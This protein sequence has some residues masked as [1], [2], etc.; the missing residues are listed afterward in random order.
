MSRIGTW[1]RA[2][3]IPMWISLVALAAVIALA[4][5]G[6]SPAWAYEENLT[7][8]CTDI[9][10]TE[11]DTFRLH[12]VRE[13]A[14]DELLE[15]SYQTMKVYWTTVS[16]TADESDYIPL[17]HE[18]QASNR[19]QSKNDRMG[20][21]FYTTEDDL[22]EL[23]EEFKV[24]V[25]NANEDGDG[26]ECT[27]EIADDDGPGSVATLISWRPD[28]DAYRRGDFIQ[29]EL[30]YN[31]HVVV[32]GGTPALGLH[33]GEGQG[34]EPNRYAT[35]YRGSEFD[36]LIFRYRVQPGDF[37]PD[38]ITVVAGELA[39]TGAV[40]T[41][42]TDQAINPKHRGVAGDAGQKVDAATRVTGV[43][44]TSAPEGGETYRLG[45]FIEATA[46]FNRSV[47]VDGDVA[48][49]L[50][51]GDG[52][53]SLVEAPYHAGSGT[54]RLVFR[55]QV[56]ADD[57]DTTG[58]RVVEGT[59][60][61]LENRTGLVGSGKIV[62]MLDG[63]EIDVRTAFDGLS[64][65]SGHKVDGRAY[66]KSVAV[67]SSPSDGDHY[68]ADERIMVALSFDR[69]VAVQPKPAIK[70]MVGDQEELARFY[71]GSLTD[72]VTFSYKVDEDD[73]DQD[74]ISVPRQEGFLA[75]GNVW[76]AD[77]RR[78]LDERIPV[79]RNQADHRVN[80]ILPTVVA[81]EIASDPA[82]GGVYRYGETIEIALE[83]DGEV[84]VLGR[85]SIQILLDGTDSPERN[86]VYSRGSGTDTLTFAY[87][88]QLAD[89]DH[90]GVGLAERDTGGFGPAT[91]RVYQAGTENT[92]M[93]HI[94][95]FGSA[96]G[97]RVDGRPYVTAT[98]V[99]STPASSG[100]Y[101]AGETISVALTYDRPM[102]VEG[103]PSIAFEIG[104]HRSEATYRGGS[105]T[106]TI[107]FGYDVQTHDRDDDGFSLP[108]G[109]GHA[110][111]DGSIF[112]AGRE[113]EVEGTYPGFGDLEAHKVA[114]QVSVSSISIGSDPGSDDTY[115]PGDTIRVLVHFDDEVIVTGAPRL[116]LDLGGSTVTANFQGI[117]DQA[118]DASD[119]TG[120]VLIF[121]YT[122]QDGDG[123]DDGISVVANSLNLHGGAIL[124][125]VGNDPDL[126]HDAA[127]FAGH[128]VGVVPP[129]LLSA[130]T[131]AD[132]QEVVLTFSENIDVRPDLRTLSRF[133]GIHVSIYPRIL[134]DIFVDGHRAHTH[135]PVISGAEL[136]FKMD[137]FIRSGQ[138]VTVGYDDVFARDLP[139]ILVDDHGNALTRFDERAVSNHSTLSADAQELWP[140]LSAYS[141]TVAEGGTGSYT[142]ALGSQPDENVT[143]TLVISPSGH[144]TAS[145]EEL[146]FTPENWSSP[147][148]V[149]LTAGTDD[150]DINFWQEIIHSST[151]E[152]FVVGHVKVLVED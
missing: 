81:S 73:L 46:Q 15:E 34:E 75:S 129:M 5:R 122:V 110:F 41:R 69:A 17:H 93:G 90:D 60:A 37:D 51:V 126:R 109:D 103:V 123:D 120:K 66:V 16:G 149:A 130:R 80:G 72:T 105:G 30:H 104:D 131:T 102:V 6:M 50:E 114:G 19:F 76:E 98:S 4:S 111:H 65:Q 91:T 40:K 124:D 52:N 24:E 88:V 62:E 56:D 14:T 113:V 35:Y 92:V 112:S 141:L 151:A 49:Q 21:T 20:R 33:I 44:I 108:A 59:S 36:Y 128:L 135:A 11:G 25:E 67:T 29:L 57:R 97:H 28:V 85:P 115:E 143:V 58:V 119:S 150:D 1:I 47:Q 121:A 95:G 74:G 9:A 87:T 139:G 125:R 39:G 55:Y 145:V 53:D 148:T 68:V 82:K 12:V 137:T 99:T 3:R 86:A 77:P 83:F 142:V 27:I 32:T 84:D 2:T 23:T 61:A 146:V 79:L 116:S 117:H 71:S 118:R 100:V 152:G 26:G 54:D 42:W 43:S 136:N 64:D 147:Q 134:I 13:D 144:L 22:S 7:V 31:E 89:I 63:T 70:I 18:G 45:E 132:G 140:V 127:T 8:E 138:Q 106:S 48:L 107:V 96:E 78:R 101:R 10:V 94:V 38:G 133:L